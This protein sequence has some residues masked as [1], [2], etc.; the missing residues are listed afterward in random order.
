[1]VARAA[2]VSRENGMREEG[3]R[4]RADAGP[5][6]VGYR[7][8]ARLGYTTAPASAATTGQLLE[9]FTA[10]LLS[11]SRKNLR[12]VDSAYYANSA[13][14]NAVDVS[15]SNPEH[16]GRGRTTFKSAPEG[17]GATDQRAADGAGLFTGRL[18]RQ[19]RRPPDVHGDDRAGRKQ[20][21]FPKHRQGGNDARR[22]AVQ[23]L[24]RS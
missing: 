22:V 15:A 20:S 17:L 10:G 3:S 4:H 8:P 21:E 13:Y 12:S 2:R 19:M 9:A 24:L 6:E 18:R 16:S 11:D 5:F 23:T 7:L 1:M 14:A